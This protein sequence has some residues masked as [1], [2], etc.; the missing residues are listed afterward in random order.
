MDTRFSTF[1][2]STQKQRDLSGFTIASDGHVGIMINSCSNEPTHPM[3]LDARLNRP[4]VWF[5]P[6]AQALL[7]AESFL[8][9]FRFSEYAL[10]CIRLIQTRSH[11]TTRAR[12]LKGANFHGQNL[13]PTHRAAACKRPQSVVEWKRLILVEKSCNQPITMMYRTAG[14][15]R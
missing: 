5:V 9:R 14:G 10:S 4:K 13:H 6:I 12:T 1:R 2:F 8:T 7:A 11:P 3:S 15:H